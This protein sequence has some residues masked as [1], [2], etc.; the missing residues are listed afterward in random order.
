MTDSG[1]GNEESA[2]SLGDAL[3]A[4]A[5]ATGEVGYLGIAREIWDSDEHAVGVRET[6]APVFD[7]IRASSRGDKTARRDLE[8]FCAAW[9]ESDVLR[10]WAV[11]FRTLAD[12]SDASRLS[13]LLGGVVANHLSDLIEELRSPGLNGF[14][15]DAGH[16]AR[17]VP[18]RLDYLPGLAQVLENSARERAEAEDLDPAVAFSAAAVVLYR[19][20]DGLIRHGSHNESVRYD[21]AVAHGNHALWLSDA[22]QREG[23]EPFSRQAVDMLRKLVILDRA[24]YL[25]DLANALLSEAWNLSELGKHARARI[26]AWEA[27]RLRDELVKADR[28][29]HLPD[30]TAGCMVLGHT[31]IAGDHLTEAIEPLIAAVGLAA[32]LGDSGEEILSLAADLLRRVYAADPVATAARLRDFDIQEPPPWLTE[33][34]PPAE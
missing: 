13:Q 20:V 4:P 16:R 14:D 12:R 6:L 8:V 22:G 34:G 9:D 11:A 18:Q 25:P 31:L 21:I 32:E 15:G 24:K 10:S 23:A 29:A 33:P 19:R 17:A 28:A 2:A 5:E 30:Y 1:V 7:A 27:V 26:L 3:R